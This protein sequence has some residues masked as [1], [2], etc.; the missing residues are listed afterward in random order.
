[1]R[2]D[3]LFNYFCHQENAPLV[4]RGLKPK[5]LTETAAA[6]HLNTLRRSTA[7]AASTAGSPIPPRTATKQTIASPAVTSPPSINRKLKPSAA[8]MATA[9]ASPL[10]ASV[11][12]SSNISGASYASQTL[13]RNYDHSAARQAFGHN[14]S[15][16]TV[17]STSSMSSFGSFGAQQTSASVANTI[18]PMLDYLELDTTANV[19]ATSHAT[20]AISDATS[21]QMS[22]D[23]KPAARLKHSHSGGVTA[24]ALT[25]GSTTG[26]TS[27]GSGSST[28][29]GTTTSSADQSES[30]IVYKFV[31]FVKTEAIKR[32]RQD[33]AHKTSNGA[34]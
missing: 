34:E 17:P 19:S 5:P 20:D 10:A 27:V 11:N 29:G 16:S 3:A 32:T 14:R 7:A 24:A 30:R 8:E 28:A 25:S 6:Q 18:L 13:P 4:N 2:I 12:A 26:G 15:N 21:V 33:R 23:T 22:V 9:S 1:M 31:D